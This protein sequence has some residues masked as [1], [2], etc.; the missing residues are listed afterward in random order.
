MNP[1]AMA[2]ERRRR[3]ALHL[4]VLA[5]AAAH[6]AAAR[7]AEACAPAY[8]PDKSVRIAGESAV[9]IWDQRAK[10]EHFIRRATFTTTA[11]DFGFLVPT[12]TRPELGDAPDSLF[13]AL[14][15]RVA[16]RLITR[17]EIQ[18]ISVGLL[19]ASLAG[20]S[21][22][23][24][25]PAA[26]APPVRVLEERRV[27]GLDAAVLEAD[28]AAALGQWLQVH[29][30]AFRPSLEA[31]LAPYVSLGWK[32]TAF[33]YAPGQG[34]GA[35]ASSAVRLSFAAERPF[36]PYREPVDQREEP[37]AH[38]DAQP[39]ERLLRVFFL[40]SAK[41]QGALGDSGARWPGQTVWADAMPASEAQALFGSLV[42]GIAQPW[43][44]T[45]E[46]RSNPRPG[47]DEIFFSP[48]G[49]ATPVHPPPVEVVRGRTLRLPLEPFVLA[50]AFAL[51][52]AQRSR[53]A[54]R[55]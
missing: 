17:E 47:T 28:S 20:D 52:L 39:P 42:G 18:D 55:P 12:P 34:G 1:T 10:K 35:V 15:Q 54:R 26:A 30:Y 46:D 3:A 22:S 37:A 33:K 36:F 23:A 16:P 4:A 44:T 53:R 49:D 11:A 25:A 19:C 50:A 31:W 32:I 5:A 14:D 7:T 13:N 40:G 9:I 43:L 51:W 24:R 38:A 45:F 21:D 27:A 29:G 2:P 41:A 48:S 8:P 6:L